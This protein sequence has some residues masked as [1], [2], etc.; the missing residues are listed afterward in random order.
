MGGGFSG[1]GQVRYV[2]ERVRQ[3]THAGLV[4]NGRLTYTPGERF[5]WQSRR[6]R[7]SWKLRY[8]PATDKAVGT[9]DGL[10]SCL[11]RVRF[12]SIG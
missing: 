4:Y 1:S 11:W 9:R 6:L 3:I 5:P 2:D 7:R 12:V 10:E 8:D